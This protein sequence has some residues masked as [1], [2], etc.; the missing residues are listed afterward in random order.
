MSSLHKIKIIYKNCTREHPWNE[1]KKAAFQEGCLYLFI[2]F[3]CYKRKVVF[4]LQHIYIIINALNFCLFFS[5]NGY[6]SL[7]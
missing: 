5:S 2:I 6:S 3:V 1:W 7:K 4:M